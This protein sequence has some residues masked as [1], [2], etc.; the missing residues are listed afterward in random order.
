[1][2]AAEQLGV[3]ARNGAPEA[4][5]ALVIGALEVDPV[6]ASELA[7]AA[8]PAVWNQVTAAVSSRLREL[9]GSMNGF[10]RALGL[11]G[12]L[13]TGPMTLEMC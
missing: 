6:F 3:S 5:A 12:M 2:M 7:F 10:C 13:A 11:T 1:M 8:G 9:Y 4:G